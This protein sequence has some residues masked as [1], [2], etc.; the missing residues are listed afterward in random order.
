MGSFT[1]RF[2][3]TALLFLFVAQSSGSALANTPKDSMATVQGLNIASILHPILG[4]IEN[5]QIVA[6]LTGNGDRYEAMHAPPPRIEPS[7][8][9][10]DAA[11][12]VAHLHPLKPRIRFG[13]RQHVSMPPLSALDPHH[14]LRDPLAM[15]RSNVA[16]EASNNLV[17]L[18]PNFIEPANP[19]SS[20]I[21]PATGPTRPSR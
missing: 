1:R 11:A 17:G 3:A 13:I 10:T 18:N 5:S 9:H 2:V 4:A 6:E 20:S 16:S 19:V 8:R 7:V 21:S 14:H 15:R 12:L